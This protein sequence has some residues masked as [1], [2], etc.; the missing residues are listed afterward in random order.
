MKKISFFFVL[1]FIFFNF[2]NIC[3]ESV[4]ESIKKQELI[5]KVEKNK[6]FKLNKIGKNYNINFIF[7][8]RNFRFYKVKV[9]S[10]LDKEL[11]L[12][13]SYGFRVYKNHILKA[14]DK[15]NDMYYEQQWFLQS[16]GADLCW[17]YFKGSGDIV[18]YVLDSGL[19]YTHPDL[20]N[21][22]Y[23]NPDEIS[24]NGIDDDNNG[25][26]DDTIGYDF[27]TEE[28]SYTDNGDGYPPDNDPMDCAAHGTAVGGIIAAETDNS[29]GVAS[30]GWKTKVYPLRV[31]Y[32]YYGSIYALESDITA[33]L[34]YAIDNGAKIINV[35]FG[36]VT[37]LPLLKEAIDEAEKKNVIIVAPSG[38]D[39]NN[40]KNYP[41]A[42]PY[43]ISVS[44][45]NRNNLNYGY[46]YGLWNDIC[47]PAVS[48]FTTVPDNGYSNVSGTSVASPIVSASLAYL[49]DYKKDLDISTIVHSLFTYSLDIDTI[50]PTL[51]YQM[52][53]GRLDLFN[54]FKNLDNPILLELSKIDFDTNKVYL[55]SDVIDFDMKIKNIGI[56]IQ[57]GSFDINLILSNNNV[58]NIYS[59]TISNFNRGDVLS[60]QNCDFTIPQDIDFNTEFIIDL[61]GTIEGEKFRFDRKYF[62]KKFN[63][64]FYNIGNKDISLSVGNN[65]LLG[66]NDLTESYQTEYNDYQLGDGLL[67]KKFGDILYTGSIWFG[68]ED[69]KVFDGTAKNI[70]IKLTDWYVDNSFVISEKDDNIRCLR[71]SY[72]DDTT[73]IGIKVE[74]N[75]FFNNNSFYL[76]NFK[77][78]NYGLDLKN[79]RF[80]IFTEFDLI[81]YAKNKV[82]YNRDEKY[83]IFSYYDTLYACLGYI[84]EDEMINFYA[85]EDYY[86]YNV[87]TLN[88]SI[89]YN[90]M[91]N[92]NIID[93]VGDLSGVL[94]SGF[95]GDFIKNDSL[96]FWYY[97]AVYEDNDS[98]D[99]I[100]KKIK[101]LYDNVNNTTVVYE[102][103]KANNVKVSIFPNPAKKFINIM[104]NKRIDKI[105]LY[106][107]EG[108]FLNRY[109]NINNLNYSINIGLYSSGSYFVKICIKDKVIIK[110]FV[111][112]K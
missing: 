30:V 96:E 47:A 2:V 111:I 37:K 10:N 103:K 20:I 86:N 84:G 55:P 26:V 77:I 56:D 108:R 44:G 33:A 90:F 42:Y 75:I 34:Y 78:K 13:K 60:I 31:A 80:G 62:S 88:D 87:N 38:N 29:I 40:M 74:E 102:N 28:P 81:N 6:L 53:L 79:P 68:G 99:F 25:Y 27:V 101:E 11:N 57:S 51:K 24:F 52:G 98:L 23:H 45:V 104:S 70:P 8:N 22:V 12:F 82:V 19:D 109:D 35:S 72:C 39:F 50:L 94:S 92:T 4:N 17:S 107:I 7:E 49:L 89:K 67:Y 61:R 54:S 46:N 91:N 112:I 65:G 83:A 106:N 100:L 59:A 66:H 71:L 76:F 110:K 63:P 69:S 32:S 64:I 58:F 9:K 16:I 105:Y 97:L 36:S 14:F 93:G 48:I 18:V 73:N 3:A 95:N 43:V 5:I 21:S 1:L 15:P 85:I 41:A